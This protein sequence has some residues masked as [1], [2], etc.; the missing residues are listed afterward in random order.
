MKDM[1]KLAIIQAF[2]TLWEIKF[3]QMVTI[4]NF[5]TVQELYSSR[6]G[7]L[8]LCEQFSSSEQTPHEKP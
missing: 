5:V 4:L 6:Q 7:R 1:I 8:L 3:E 2:T